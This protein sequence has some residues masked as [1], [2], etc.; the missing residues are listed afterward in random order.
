MLMFLLVKLLVHALKMKEHF[1]IYFCI[2]YS[3]I[4]IFRKLLNVRL[5]GFKKKIYPKVYGINNNVQFFL[6]KES[7]FVFL[8]VTEQ[9]LKLYFY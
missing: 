7:A 4:F 6:K 5:V 8:K 9:Q 3:F 1:R 2:F